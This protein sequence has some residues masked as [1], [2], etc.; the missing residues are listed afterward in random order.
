MRCKHCFE[1]ANSLCKPHSLCG[2]CHTKFTKGEIEVDAVE[3]SKKDIKYVNWVDED[4][5]QTDFTTAQLKEYINANKRIKRNLL[6][7]IGRLER[8]RE[9]SGINYI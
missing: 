3:Q 2:N 1:E 4:F 9:A 6:V 8:I 5:G 7:I